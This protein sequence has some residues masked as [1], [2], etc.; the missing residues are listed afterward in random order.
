MRTV[1]LCIHFSMNFKNSSTRKDNNASTA[2]NKLPIEPHTLRAILM[3]HIKSL[4]KASATGP[5]QC[6]SFKSPPLAPQLHYSP[7]IVKIQSTDSD[8]FLPTKHQTSYHYILPRLTYKHQ[9]EAQDS[10][11][12]IST[13]FITWWKYSTCAFRAV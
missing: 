13:V 3:C 2:D 12:P 1:T 7:D 4:H 11:K 10:H 5:T 9:H 8:G 6:V